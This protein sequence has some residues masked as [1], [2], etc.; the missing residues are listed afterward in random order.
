MAGSALFALSTAWADTDATNIRLIFGDEGTAWRAGEVVVPLAEHN[1]L[2]GDNAFPA[3]SADGAKVAILYGSHKVFG[4]WALDIIDIERQ[5]SVERFYLNWSPEELRPL[6]E[7]EA[8]GTRLEVANSFLENEGFRTIDLFFDFYHTQTYA[9]AR[10]YR[11]QHSNKELPEFWQT[12]VEPW[13]IVYWNQEDRLEIFDQNSYE[14][15]FSVSLP[16]LGYEILHGHV[17]K[18]RPNPTKGW[19]SDT[20]D[21]LVIASFWTASHV[22]CDRPPRWLITRLSSS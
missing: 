17:C 20:T 5:N 22:S 14:P 16:L 19:Y 9:Y 21:V 13:R 12:E 1:H 11:R 8:V 3:I 2:W 7:P 4:G 10:D 18:Q 6:R 15:A